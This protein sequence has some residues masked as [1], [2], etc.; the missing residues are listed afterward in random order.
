MVA[1]SSA[2]ARDL[3][4]AE[5]PEVPPAPVSVSR[6][7]HL[8]PMFYIGYD[9]RPRLPSMFLRRVPVLFFFADTFVM[10]LG[11]G[12]SSRISPSSSTNG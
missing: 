5:K 11:V 3:E 7:L 1:E 10:C 12:Y 9:S 8:H 6:G 4:E 2:Q